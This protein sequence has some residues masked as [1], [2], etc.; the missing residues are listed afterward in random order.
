MSTS[1]IGFKPPDEKWKKMKKVYDVCKETGVNL[2]ADVEDFFDGG[3]NYPDDEGVRVELEDH[4]S[5]CCK[6]Y[7]D[8]GSSGYDIDVKK[9][10]KDVTIIRFYN[11]W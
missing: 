1:V 2:S 9:L 6:E 11:S 4:E 8:D 3:D 7:S 5:G 10:P